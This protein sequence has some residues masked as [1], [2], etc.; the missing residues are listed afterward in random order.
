MRIIKIESR[1]YLVKERQFKMLV[2]KQK[3]LE[4]EKNEVYKN[5]EILNFI[6]N[7]KSSLKSLGNVEL[8]IS[9]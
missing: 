2:E 5:N 4:D 7:I 8:D 1:A 6:N 9:L 3:E